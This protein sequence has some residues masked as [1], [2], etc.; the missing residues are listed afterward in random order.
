MDALF[1][2]S[3]ANFPFC[4]SLSKYSFVR[5]QTRAKIIM[6]SYHV[7]IVT[8]PACERLEVLSTSY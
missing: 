1:K 5:K 3:I 4:E 7:C 8:R 2:Y 6:A